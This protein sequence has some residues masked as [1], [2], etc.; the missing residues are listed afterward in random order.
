MNKIKKTTEGWDAAF[1]F[2]SSLS[3]LREWP[4]SF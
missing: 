2:F 4:R 3:K 1:R